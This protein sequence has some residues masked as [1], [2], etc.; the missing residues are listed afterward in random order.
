MSLRGGFSLTH[1]LVLNNTDG[2]IPLK[3]LRQ[4]TPI[5]L[6]TAFVLM[7]PSALYGTVN[8]AG[9]EW[10]PSRIG[11]SVVSPGANLFVQFKDAGKLAGHGGCNRFFGQYKISGN[12]INIGP[13]GSTRMACA[14]SVM[15][16]EKAFLSALEGAKSFR[17]DKAKLMLFDASGKEQASLIQTDW[18]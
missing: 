15:A 8:L 1:K 16:L 11:T 4:F 18:D 12:D 7:L 3:Y 10:R 17:R 13:I 2:L 5:L 9:S 6:L 14:E